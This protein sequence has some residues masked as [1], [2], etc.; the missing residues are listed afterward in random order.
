MKVNLKLFAGLF[1]LGTVAAVVPTVLTSCKSEA[2]EEDKNEAIH[3]KSITFTFDEYHDDTNN[4]KKFLNMTE[5]VFDPKVTDFSVTEDNDIEDLA[6]FLKSSN[7][8]H[9]YLTSKSSRARN[10]LINEN[11]PLF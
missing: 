7:G 10:L 6:D 5:C 2:K 1:A 3:E 8:T 9:N 11:L 4:M